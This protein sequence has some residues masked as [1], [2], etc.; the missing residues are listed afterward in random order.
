MGRRS[1]TRSRAAAGGGRR[2]PAGG[3]SPA[4]RLPAPRRVLAAY[5]VAALVLGA[6]VLAGI[7]GLG[8]AA[9]PLLVLVFAL[10]AGG[11]VFSWARRRLKGHALTDEDRLL[12][13]TATGV[14]ALAVLLA[15]VSAVLVALR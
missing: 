13:N 12:Q 10:A 6:A 2:A 14:L 11:L 4:G 5:L 8:G 15:A 9:G 7:V 1:R 3:A